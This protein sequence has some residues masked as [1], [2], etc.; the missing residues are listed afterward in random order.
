MPLITSLPCEVIAGVLRNLDNVSYLLPSILT[1]RHFYSSF[2][3]NP[4]LELDILRRQV[5]PALLP[6]S[7]AVMEASQLPR[8]RTA[9]SIQS[10]LDT[11]YNEPALLVSR[12]RKMPLD[13]V[14]KMGRTHDIIESLAVGFASDAWTLL[15]QK[16]PGLSGSLVL[17]STEFFRFCRAFYRVELYFSLFRGDQDQMNGDFEDGQ[18]QWFFSKHP[19]W[20]NEQLACVHDFLEKKVS[21]GESDQSWMQA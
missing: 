19:P 20:V 10:L 7:I 5:T 21:E 14:L 4:G 15:G 1:C 12:A 17:S 9:A 6:Y 2:K 8:P 18:T 16:E 11:L 3:E 13:T